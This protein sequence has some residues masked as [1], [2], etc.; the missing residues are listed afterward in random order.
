MRE[1]RNIF[2][3]PL[4]A[5]ILVVIS[6]FT[7]ATYMNFSGLKDYHWLWGLYIL[8]TPTLH[9]R[10][11][12]GT[13]HPSYISTILIGIGGIV[14]IIYAIK[15][16]LGRKEFKNMRDITI[17]A[18]L[19]IITG[20]ILWL[21]LVPLLF[22]TVELLG[23]V[24]P[25]DILSFWR[26]H[27]GADMQ[28]HYVGFGIIGGII[29]VVLSFITIGVTHHYSKG[30]LITIPEKVKIPEKIPKIEK[31]ILPTKTVN[32]IEPTKL[33]YCPACGKK[34]EVPDANF[35]TECGHQFI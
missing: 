11:F 15:L 25:G 7:P 1:P 6:L 10:G 26:F 12:L 31:P 3:I 9:A 19:L 13:I 29:A 35:C 18:I 17:F 20:E 33:N 5:G 30:E 28:L 16:R 21:I 2:I 14:S 8:D 24:I 22:P 32:P 4:I 23:P 34:I 27:Y